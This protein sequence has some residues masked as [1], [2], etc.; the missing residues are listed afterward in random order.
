MADKCWKLLI[1]IFV[2][3]ASQAVFFIGMTL[4]A[5]AGIMGPISL[6]AGMVGI[7]IGIIMGAGTIINSRGN[8]TLA[9]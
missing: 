7:V 6:I 2:V 3:V 5:G 4:G 8:K 1:A 9:G